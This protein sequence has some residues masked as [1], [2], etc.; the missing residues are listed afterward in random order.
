MKD[1]GISYIPNANQSSKEPSEPIV[2]DKLSIQ[3]VN[4]LI[5][6]KLNLFKEDMVSK[7]ELKSLI[8]EILKDEGFQNTNIK[9][10]KTP[11]TYKTEAEV[12][13]IWAVLESKKQLFICISKDEKFTNWV[14]LLGDGSN[15]II[16]KEKIIITFDNT[17]TGGQYG[18][19][20]SDL[21]L[22]F[23]NGFATPNK[24]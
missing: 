5:D 14:D 11:P 20:M 2:S 3:K 9:I 13:E 24:V 12:G 7:E 6:K 10:S 1:Y 16:P 17:T 22:G 21:R 19:C 4:E 8:Q 23:E 18:G 15:D